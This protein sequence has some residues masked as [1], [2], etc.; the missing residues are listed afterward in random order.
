MALHQTL[1]GRR[2]NSH[3]IWTALCEMH[4]EEQITTEQ[5]LE[6]V[7]ALFDPVE[8]IPIKEELA[9]LE[10]GLVQRTD[11]TA[12]MPSYPYLICWRADMS[13]VTGRELCIDWYDYNQVVALAI[14]LGPGMSVIRHPNRYN[15]NITHTERER[16]LEPFV[17]VLYRTGRKVR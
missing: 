2:G 6:I 16:N 3:W 11:R 12:Q 5:L 7:D 15:Y 9:L 13:A 8:A 14:K 10:V 1:K 4:D 17:E